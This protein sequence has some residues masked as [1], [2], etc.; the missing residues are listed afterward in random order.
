MRDHQSKQARIAH[1]G[2]AVGLDLQTTL[3]SNPG[4]YATFLPSD[5][6]RSLDLL[7]MRSLYVD[8]WAGR[9]VV[10]GT[11]PVDGKAILDN[12]YAIA[13]ERADSFSQFHASEARSLQFIKWQFE[14]ASSSTVGSDG[15]NTW[16]P[17][18]IRDQAANDPEELRI[19]L[20]SQLSHRSSALGLPD[21]ASLYGILDGLLAGKPSSV[22]T[23]AM[24]R[25][26]QVLAVRMDAVRDLP[27][28]GVRAI[29]M[30]KLL[31]AQAQRHGVVLDDK[32]FP[33]P[34]SA[35]TTRGPHA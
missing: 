24:N 17:D 18:A 14:L 31:F 25:E 22:I 3:F 30:F 13:Q 10:P 28:A 6:G 1:Y 15:L 26:V 2:K 11:L 33:V 19:D 23:E 8:Y 34:P 27:T 9:F 12:L 29:Q 16:P 21:Y 7:K 35:A 4:P 32:N 5:L 20:H